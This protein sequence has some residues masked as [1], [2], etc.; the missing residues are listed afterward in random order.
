MGCILEVLNAIWTSGS[1][2]KSPAFGLCHRCVGDMIQSVLVFLR[3]ACFW[4]GSW[5][6]GYTVKVHLFILANDY[7]WNIFAPLPGS[8]EYPRT[9]N[10]WIQNVTK[11]RAQMLNTPKAG[12]R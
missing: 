2:C 7:S 9:Y 1:F 11:I 10:E 8:V 4:V 12:F 5:I 6:T 3:H